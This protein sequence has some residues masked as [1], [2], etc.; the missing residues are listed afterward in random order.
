MIYNFRGRASVVT[1]FAPYMCEPCAT[2]VDVLLDTRMHFR[3]NTALLAPEIKCPQC[4]KMLVFDDIPER[5]FSFIVQ[6]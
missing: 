3:D 5:Y 4:G 6:Q 2:E 1:F